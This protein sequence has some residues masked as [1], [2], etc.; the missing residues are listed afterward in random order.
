[1]TETQK[2]LFRGLEAFRVP[3]GM[4]AEV[5]VRLPEEEKQVQMMETLWFHMRP[6]RR[7][8]CWPRRGGSAGSNRADR[9]GEHAVSGTRPGG[10]GQPDAAGQCTGKRGA[11]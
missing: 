10:G 11:E 1:M 4:A 6:Q 9:G 7:R 3:K 5:F 2:L 8:R